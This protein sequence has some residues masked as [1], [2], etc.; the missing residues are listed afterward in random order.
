MTLGMPTEEKT[1][2]KNSHT[3]FALTD[4]SGKANGNRVCELVKHK[5]KLYSVDLLHTCSNVK[6]VLD[7]VVQY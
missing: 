3:A 4:L 7:H 2:N 5:Q 6:V 1:C